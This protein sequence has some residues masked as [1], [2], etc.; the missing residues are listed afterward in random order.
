MSDTATRVL[1]SYP[2]DFSGWGRQQ[3][4]TVHFRAWLRKSHETADVG[5]VWEEFVDVGCC[6][7]TYDVPLRVESVEGGHDLDENT[8]IEYTERESCDIGGSWEVQSAAGPA[9]E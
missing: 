2:A 7:S 6:G 5:D 8:T 4:D 9:A 1:L 3:V